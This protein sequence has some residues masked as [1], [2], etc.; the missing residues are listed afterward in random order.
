MQAEEWKNYFESAHIVLEE[1]K[2]YLCELDR[3]LGD[4]DHGITMSIGWKAVQ[5]ALHS[6]LADET[7]CGKIA[8]TAGRSFLSAVGSSVG[9][10]YASG[11]MAGAKAVKNKTELSMEDMRQFWIEFTNGVQERSQAEPGDKTMV[12]VLYPVQEAL[13]SED[14][15]V[16]KKFEQ[17]SQAAK[18]GMEATREMS[19]Q[20][21]RSSRLGERSIGHQDPGAT[22]M[23]LLFSTFVTEALNLKTV[24]EEY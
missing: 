20:K 12:D 4:G 18:D 11:F 24:K 17:A 8:M 2:T 13:Q 5:E 16:E 7:D 23:Q 6:K 14:G 1:N 3:A 10:L 9:P 21:G 22:S 19:S 15:T